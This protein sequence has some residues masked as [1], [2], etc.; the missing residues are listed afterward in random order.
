M[1]M[2]KKFAM[3]LATIVRAKRKATDAAATA[4]WWREAFPRMEQDQVDQ[5]KNYLRQ[6]GM[7]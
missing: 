1:L 5:V 7:G 4:A 3:R 2:H 6:M